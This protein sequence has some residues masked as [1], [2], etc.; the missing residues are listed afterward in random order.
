ME[1]EHLK[2][3]IVGH[4]DHGKSTLIGRLLYDTESL[5]E[6][7]IEEIKK[8]CEAA[9]QELEFAY[10]IDHLEEEREQNITIDTTQTFFK[11]EKR[12]Y[13][14]I[15]A[16]G[17]REFLKNM[18]TGASQAEAAILIVDAEEGI[19]EQ[20]RRHAYLLHMLGIDQVIVII[21]KMDLVS[22]KQERFEEIKNELLT[23]LKNLKITPSYTIP[24]SAKKG[25]NIIRN[26]ENMP[27]YKDL[28]LLLSLDTFK[29]KSDKSDLPLRMPVQDV[30]KIGNKRIIVGR[31]EAGTIEEGK[32]VI[33]LPNNEKSVITSVEEFLNENKKKAVFEESTGVT[34]KD[35]LFVDRGQV[36]CEED[37]L[38]VVTN[39]LKANL[40]WMGKKDFKKGE[41][42]ILKCSTQET[43]CVLEKIEKK[44]N[45]STLETTGNDAESITNKEVSEIILALDISLVV[46]DFNQTPELGRFVIERGNNTVAGGIIKIKE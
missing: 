11:T 25:D 5:P 34:I 40:F 8:I 2:F 29:T 14:I 35:K 46:D 30:Y 39:R 37:N 45:S 44:I 12:R 10:V 22:Y 1:A 24:V 6:G 20:T 42:V 27:W 36:I 7:K 19:Q 18:I 21:N 16:P 4:V 3:V 17:H 38:P 43:R 26:S 23:F 41:R 32:K 28:T 9:G 33:F 15:D 13:I 31:V